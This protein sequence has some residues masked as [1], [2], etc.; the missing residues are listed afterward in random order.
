MS[1]E[2]STKLRQSIGLLLSMGCVSLAW[3]QHDMRI[4][5][6][7]PAIIAPGDTMEIAGENLSNA[8]LTKV[9]LISSL[10]EAPA[11]D[12]V[13]LAEVS[14]VDNHRVR[15]LIPATLPAGDYLVKIENDASERRGRSNLQRVTIGV[16]GHNQADHARPSWPSTVIDRVTIRR[17]TLELEGK[18]FG[19][20]PGNRSVTIH[21]P[22]GEPYIE[23]RLEVLA[24][25][26]TF[27]QARLPVAL[28][29]GDYFVFVADDVT[30]GSNS[31]TVI[32]PAWR[33][34]TLAPDK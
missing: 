28:R 4:N 21:Q 15:V 19:I 24:W 5:P 3:A 26:D 8:N 7:R 30:T 2:L 13:N 34:V 23:Q 14:W 1:K 10:I 29:P 20:E 32:I 33:E 31:Q 25:N 11:Y 18:H 17:Q 12:F 9:V 27:I 22:D 6:I 16:P